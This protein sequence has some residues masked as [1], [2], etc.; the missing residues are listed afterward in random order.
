MIDWRLLS[1]TTTCA[2]LKKRK[3]LDDASA[4]L[5]RSPRT[6]ECTKG[7]ITV[8]EPFIVNS[9]AVEAKNIANG[10]KLDTVK[11]FK[12][13]LVEQAELQLASGKNHRR[14]RSFFSGEA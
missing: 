5:I 2:L 10:S 6:E 1:K 13:D 4:K 9:Q 11:K 12:D 8:V 3:E 14:S 7:S